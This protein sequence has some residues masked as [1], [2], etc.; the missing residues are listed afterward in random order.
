MDIDLFDLLKRSEYDVKLGPVAEEALRFVGAAE[1]KILKTPG[2]GQSS[3]SVVRMYRVRMGL[4]RFDR[5]AFVGLDE[6]IEVLSEREVTVNLSVIEMEKGIISIWLSNSS[7]RPVGIVI[8][9][10][11]SKDD[12]TLHSAG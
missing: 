12:D 1:Y 11:I 10:F 3:F 7:G 5:D 6:S 2:P 9:K 8:A 4:E